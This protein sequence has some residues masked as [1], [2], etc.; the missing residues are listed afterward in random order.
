MS[1]GLKNF[2]GNAILYGSSVNLVEP[3]FGL[4]T[5]IENS[6]ILFTEI[7]FPYYDK[8]VSNKV[9]RFISVIHSFSTKV[10]TVIIG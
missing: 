5:L 6:D 7:L 4:L 10:K 9:I 3:V 2:F 1:F 8:L